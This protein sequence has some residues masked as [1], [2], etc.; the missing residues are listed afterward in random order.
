[1]TAQIIKNEKLVIL[2]THVM[3]ETKGCV[4]ATCPELMVTTQGKTIQEA[5]K[6]LKEAVILYLETL[7]QL[8][9]RNSVFKEKKIKVLKQKRYSDK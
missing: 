3:K 5:N 1:M 8:G 9:I 2:V 4:V 7:E 6:N